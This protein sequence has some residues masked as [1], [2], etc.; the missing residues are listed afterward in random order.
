MRFTTSLDD[1]NECLLEE[2]N[3][4]EFV[5]LMLLCGTHKQTGI[6]HSVVFLLESKNVVAL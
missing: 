4:P 2:D 5:I 1:V 3:F 6:N